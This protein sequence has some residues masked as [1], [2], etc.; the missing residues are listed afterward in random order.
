MM[1]KKRK[2]QVKLSRSIKNFKRFSQ[3]TPRIFQEGQKY[4]KK[5]SEFSRSKEHL[6]LYVAQYPPGEYTPRTAILLFR[7]NPFEA[8]HFTVLTSSSNINF[9]FSY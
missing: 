3:R 9:M 8:L 6:E 5:R 2:E 4:Y 1:L 7:R